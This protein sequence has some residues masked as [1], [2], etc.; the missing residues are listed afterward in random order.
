MRLS[1]SEI[2]HILQ[3]LASFCTEHANNIIVY[4]YGSRAVDNTRGGDIDLLWLVPKNIEEDLN[5]NKYK[6]LVALK[7]LIGEQKIDL[8]IISQHT[9]DKE[10]FYQHVMQ[11][12]VKLNTP[13]E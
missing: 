5:I 3:V 7:E 9:L 10:I 12:A 1:N 13:H 8:S 11:T 4:L 2:H 6:I